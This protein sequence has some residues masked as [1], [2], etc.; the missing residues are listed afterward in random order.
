MHEV[1]YSGVLKLSISF[2]AVNVWANGLAV[3]GKIESATT[4]AAKTKEFADFAKI[5]IEFM[6]ESSH[7]ALTIHLFSQP[8]NNFLFLNFARKWAFFCNT[9]Y[10]SPF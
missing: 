7:I 4:R 1:V 6:F 3:S 10:G 8:I 9:G 5:V 2:F